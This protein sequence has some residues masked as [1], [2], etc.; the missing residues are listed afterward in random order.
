MISVAD[1][2]AV[3]CAGAAGC[4]IVTVFTRVHPFASFTVTVCVP[5]AT[6]LNIFDDW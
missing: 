6:A 4:V 2:A 5:A 1:E 3:N